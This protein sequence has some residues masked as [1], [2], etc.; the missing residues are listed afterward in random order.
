MKITKLGH[1][2]FISEPKEG[3]RIMT[4]PGAFSTLQLSEENISAILITHEHNDHLHIDSLRKVLQNNPKAIVITNTAVGKFLDE[5]GIEYIKIED[6]QKYDLNGV[7]IVGFGSKHA[8]IYENYGQVQNTGYMIDAVCYPGDSF[9][10]PISKVDILALPVTG[11]WM[12]IKDAIDYAK[13]LKPR[14]VFPVHDAH[15]HDWAAFLWR[16]PGNWL[17]EVGIKFKK[18]ELGK[19]ENL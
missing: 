6:G 1:C 5:A 4:D 19:E 18:L 7:N 17:E 3:L 14:I 9:S 8:E 16:G 10:K 12:R 15:I 13:D 11:P 2:C